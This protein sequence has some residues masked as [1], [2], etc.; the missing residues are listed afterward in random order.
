MGMR[1]WRTS[2]DLKLQLYLSVVT[3]LCGAANGSQ[4]RR[5]CPV[6]PQVTGGCSAIYSKLEVRLLSRFA[7]ML[8]YLETCDSGTALLQVDPVG[9]IMA[10]FSEDCVYEDISANASQ[11]HGG[12]RESVELH[13]VKLLAY[14]TV[15]RHCF[16]LDCLQPCELPWLHSSKGLVLFLASLPRR[17]RQIC[18][19][20]RASRKPSSASR[21]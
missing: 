17:V 20:C 7:Q 18:R 16:V 10:E 6:S 2:G 3:F 1:S 4:T 9:R 15:G 14:A 11:N 12:K 19:T 13:V 8:S 21:K 5:T